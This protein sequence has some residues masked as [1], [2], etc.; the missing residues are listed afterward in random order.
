MYDLNLLIASFSL[1]RQYPAQWVFGLTWAV[2]SSKANIHRPQ[3]F[4]QPLYAERHM[5]R[6]LLDHVVEINA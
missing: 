6:L 3:R 4:K 1:V 5:V 2:C